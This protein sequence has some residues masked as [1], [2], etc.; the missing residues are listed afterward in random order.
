MVLSWEH[1]ED[2]YNWIAALLTLNGLL[3]SA[4]WVLLKA[5]NHGA[6][7][8]VRSYIPLGDFFSPLS[9][10]LILILAGIGLFSRRRFGFIMAAYTLAVWTLMSVVALFM[11]PMDSTLIA[12]L[13]I[14]V[15]GAS[16]HHFTV[17]RKIFMKDLPEIIHVISFLMFL[18]GWIGFS[19]GI[20]HILYTSTLQTTFILGAGLLM[21][22]GAVALAAKSKLGLWYS[23]GVLLAAVL[24]DSF[25]LLS[26]GGY[27]PFYRLT[28]NAVGVYYLQHH[29]NVFYS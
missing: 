1:V 2:K 29:Q 7:V 4:V 15:F 28:L 23:I 20:N 25:M 9:A 19:Y 8:L 18:G 24:F 22:E 5:G 10:G 26:E 13:N 27:Q 6:V 21:M 16:L 3:L 12:L 17:N 14:I 11:A